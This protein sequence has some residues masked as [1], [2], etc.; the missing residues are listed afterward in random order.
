MKRKKKQ[1][2]FECLGALA[3]ERALVDYINFWA[4]EGQA[5][6]EEQARDLLQGES[7]AEDG[8]KVEQ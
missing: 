8:T 6:T 1:V 5:I 7:F 3:Q 2:T 4:Q